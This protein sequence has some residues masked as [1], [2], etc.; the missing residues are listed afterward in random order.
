MF[1]KPQQNTRVAAA[2]APTTAIVGDKSLDS[3]ELRKKTYSIKPLKHFSPNV[4][5]YKQRKSFRILN[6]KEGKKF[7]GREK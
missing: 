5:Q 2:A 3:I 7:F 1:Y 6:K 4:K